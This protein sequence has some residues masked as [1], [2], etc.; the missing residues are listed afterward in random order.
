MK[1]SSVNLVSCVCTDT[2]RIWCCTSKRSYS[3]GYVCRHSC[4]LL[5]STFGCLSL[6]KLLRF[7]PCGS[8]HL[9]SQCALHVPNTTC[10]EVCSNVDP[11]LL[12]PAW[13][14]PSPP[15]SP[16]MPD[17]ERIVEAGYRWARGDMR[18][19]PYPP[20]STPPYKKFRGSPEYSRYGPPQ[21]GRGSYYSNYGPPPRSGGYGSPYS[22]HG[23]HGNYGPPRSHGNYQPYGGYSSHSQRGG[24]GGHRGGYG[25]PRGGGYY[26]GGHGGYGGHHGS[27]GSRGGYG[28]SRGGRDRRY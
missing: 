22:S 20:S 10:T 18:K 13:T 15:L 28:G 19:R 1:S 7:V 4:S 21:G 9:W 26:G 27:Y 2:C 11:V 5:N 14:R 23:Y 25:S 8:V 6:T 12:P 24:Y 3:Y 17:A 16:G